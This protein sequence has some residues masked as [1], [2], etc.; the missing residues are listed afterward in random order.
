MKVILQAPKLPL[1]FIEER[2]KKP[3][4]N[5]HP[6]LKPSVCVQSM[7]STIDS[8]PF[9]KSYYPQTPLKQPQSGYHHFTT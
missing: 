5:C 7:N 4:Q 1:Y 2:L 6:Y 3:G 8:Y 9:N